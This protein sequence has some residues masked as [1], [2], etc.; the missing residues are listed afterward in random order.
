VFIVSRKIGDRRD[1]IGLSIISGVL[2]ATALIEI[3]IGSFTVVS[4]NTVGVV[5]AFGQYKG[6]VPAGP[7]LLAPQDNVEEFGTRIQPLEM[8]G[9]GIRFQGNSGGTAN[10]LVEWRIQSDNEPDIHQLWSDYRTFDA[11]QNRILQSRARNALNVV[12]AGYTPN[13]GVSGANI[14]KIQNDT[15]T[16]MRGDLQNT[17]VAVERVTVRQIDPDAASQDRINRQVQATA[18]LS[19]MAINQE[20]A[21]REAAIARIR[22]SAQTPGTL[23]QS[24]LDMVEQWDAAKHGPLPATFDC[25]LGAGKT[26]IVGK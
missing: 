20:I 4:A 11:I 12:L 18:D 9:V 23:S 2:A 5:T 24:C 13:D 21:D 6:I 1:R 3:F 26:V 10:L 8:D 7:H 25:G 16:N 22:A 17:G 15:L 14:T 19:R